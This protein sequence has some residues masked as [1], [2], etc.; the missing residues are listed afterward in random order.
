MIAERLQT[1]RESVRDS[2]KRLFRLGLLKKEEEGEVSVKD[3]ALTST[4]KRKYPDRNLLDKTSR[5]KDVLEE[6]SEHNQDQTVI[7]TI[8]LSVDPQRLSESR[9]RIRRFLRSLSKYLDRGKKKEVYVLVGALFPLSRS[10]T[11]SNK[12]LSFQKENSTT[13]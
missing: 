3:V 11:N 13:E 5:L 10:Q 2:C 4:F 12:N 9:I 7:S 1:D 8:T 6:M